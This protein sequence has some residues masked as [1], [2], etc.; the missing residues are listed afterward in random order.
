MKKKVEDTWNN[1]L[2]RFYPLELLGKM[3]R[4]ECLDKKGFHCRLCEFVSMR[5]LNIHWAKKHK[6]E[7]EEYIKKFEDYRN[8]DYAQISLYKKRPTTLTAFG[9]KGKKLE[10]LWTKEI[11]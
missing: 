11:K 9:L 4:W 2:K 3:A 10:K 8:V 6:K 7:K 5:G 1:I